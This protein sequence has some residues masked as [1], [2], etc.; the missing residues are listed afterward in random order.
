MRVTFRFIFVAVLAVT[1]W[2][3]AQDSMAEEY[4]RFPVNGADVYC[5]RNGSLRMLSGENVLISGTRMVIA[6]PGWRS[7]VSQ[8]RVTPEGAYPRRDG[9]RLV[10]RGT[11]PD[12][13]QGITWTFEQRVE[14]VERGIRL[15]YA[16]APSADTQIGEAV[17]FIDLPASYWQGAPILLQPTMAGTFPVKRGGARHFLTGMAFSSV[18][19]ERKTGQLCFE[20]DHITQCT[21]QDVRRAN[22]DLFQIY[23][24]ISQAG[25]LEAGR[26]YRLDMTIIPNDRRRHSLPVTEVTARGEPAIRSVRLSADAAPRYG[27]VELTCEVTGTWD[28]PFDP[29]EVTLDAEVTDPAGRAVTVPGFFSQDY[30]SITSRGGEALIPKG[31]PTWKIRYT[32]V[33]SGL[34]RVVVILRNSGKIVRHDPLSFVCTEEMA[35]HGFVRVSDTNAHYFAYEDGAP[36]FPIGENVALIHGSG[37]AETFAVYRKLADAGGDLVRSWWCYSTSDLGS[38]HTGREGEAFGMIKLANAWRIDRLVTEAERLGLHM[39]CCLETQQNLRR[40]KTWGRFTY[41]QANG[42]PL[43]RPR[44]F[45]TNADAAAAFRARLRYVVARWGYSTAVFSWQFWN[46]VSACNEFDAKAVSVWHR[47]MARYLRSIDPWRHLIHTNF[48]NLDGYREVDGLAEMEV[49]STNSYSRR[50]MGQTAYWAGRLMATEYDKPYLL[51]EYGVGHRGGWVREDPDGVI[52][53]NGLWGSVVSGSAGTAMPWGCYHWIDRQGFYRYW[54]PIA[55]FVKG[56]P[57]HRRT[58]QPINV[59]SFT[60]ADAEAEPHYAGVFF[61]GW[62][63]NYAYTLCGPAPST[64]R[65]T[66]VGELQDQASLR[67][68]LRAGQQQQFDLTCPVAGEMVI[69]VPEISSSG[70]PVLEVVIDGKTV[71]SQPL[72]QAEED[73]WAY[74][75]SH[76]VPITQGRHTLTV[77]NAGKGTLWTGFELTRFRRREG[78]DLDVYGMQCSDIIL[79]WLRNPQFIW[80]Y[81]R[82]GRK[83]RPQPEGI[84]TLSGVPDGTYR[85]SW[86][87]TVADRD[88]GMTDVTA[89]DGTLTLRTPRIT[90]SA[91]GKIRRMT[92]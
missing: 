69:H 23:P 28:N 53:H 37:L 75:R 46:E 51:T 48:G 4:T 25:K 91:A 21:V 84:L 47:D 57:F 60:F 8:T 92:P 19:G 66:P 45:F 64:Y 49:V 88:L 27:H 1:G 40:D 62:P 6:A 76:A 26:E 52:V 80:I 10:W 34:Y 70:R 87:D 36:F 58:W 35:G 85:V 82:E 30:G 63:R 41:N 2:G 61:E 13:K 65:V 72:V 54:R 5:E 11:I 20:F 31:D 22:R 14:P 24:R 83:V 71:L 18:L 73:A 15:S 42:G 86:V 32:P 12:P 43:S 44:E 74:W 78:P 3:R 50:D 55:A 7:A 77:R 9:K 68:A 67:G 33:V 81:R 56:I 79:L 90:H 89:S 59:K 29:K 38:W 16:I 39:M 17:V